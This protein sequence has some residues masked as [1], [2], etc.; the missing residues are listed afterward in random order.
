MTKLDIYTR[1]HTVN[2]SDSDQEE[3]VAENDPPRLPPS[4]VVLDTETT[5]DLGLD[6]EFGCYAVCDWLDGIYV[7]REY[8]ILFDKLKSEFEQV[9]REYADC[10]PS[11][12]VEPGQ[13]KLR[14]RTHTDFIKNVFWPVLRAGGAAVGLNLGFDLSRIAIGYSEKQ[15]GRSFDFF[16]R[17]YL[18]KKTGKRKLSSVVPAIT[19]TSIDSKKSFYGLHFSFAHKADG[20]PVLSKEEVAEFRKSRFVDVRT[21]AFSLTN[22]SYSL[23]TLLIALD[24]PADVMKLKYVPGP[25]TE[26]KIEYCFHDV[27][28]TLWALNKLVAEFLRH[29]IKLPIDR[30]YSPVSLA[31]SYLKKMNIIPPQEK[32]DIPPEFQAAA[33]EAFYAGRAETKIRKIEMPVVYLDFTSQYPSVFQLLRGQEIVIAESLAF[34]ECTAEA[35]ALLDGLKREDLF[36]RDVWPQL[37]FF[38]QLTPDGDILPVRAAYNGKTPNIAFNHFVYDQPIFYA[39]PELADAK[40]SGNGKSPKLLKAFRVVP[41]GIQPGLGPVMLRGEVPIDPLEGDLAP[42]IVESRARVKKSNRWLA[43]FLKVMANGGMFYGLFAQVSP[44]RKDQEVAVQVFTGNQTF[45]SLTRDIEKTGDWYCPLLA[46]LIVSAGHLLLAMAERSV[47]DAGSC[48]VLMDTDSLAAVSSEHSRFIPCPGGPHRLP[49]GREAVKALS[50][51]ETLETVVEPFDRLHP[52]D[53]NRV[54]DHFLK[55]DDINLG[56]DGRQRQLYAFSISSK[57]YCLYTYSGDGKRKI[58]KVSAHGLGYLMPPFDDPPEARKTEGREEHKWI[59]EAWEWILA[60]ELDG[61]EAARSY[62]MPWFAYPAMMQLT[63]TTPHAI[64]RLKH[65]PW[66]RPMNFMNAPLIAH[67]LLP[68]EV[69]ADHFSLVGPYNPNSAMWSD[70]TYFNRYDGKPYRIGVEPDAIPYLSYGSILQS[71]RLHPESKFLGPDG[72]TCNSDTRGVLQR[73]TVDGI[74]KYPLRKESNRRWA[75]GNDLSLIEDDEDDPTGGIFKRDGKQS[76]HHVKQPLPA[77]VQ[78]WLNTLS[79]KLIERELRIDRNSLRNG[80]NGK[81]VARIAQKK[82]LVLFRMAKRGI[83]VTEALKA[84]RSASAMLGKLQ[85]SKLRPRNKVVADPTLKNKIANC[86]LRELM[87]ETGLS[88]HTIEAI[89][90]GKAIRRKTLQRVVQFLDGR[91]G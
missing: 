16:T 72:A 68:P 78:E 38:G 8:G 31:K 59:Y 56:P 63:V 47:R 81:P 89:R 43:N 40:I 27:K 6:L 70:A 30:A 84:M 44:E 24:A 51:E 4:V 25:I 26:E 79:L 33:M 86:G 64:K 39:G 71:Y 91:R 35:Q 14:V 60:R 82:L 61:E 48:H 62:R 69:A 80:R 87:R 57:R 73:M 66:A 9:I 42:K 67:A 53:R 21:L 37:R 85:N 36:E 55:V 41:Q 76:Y 13:P 23:E 7:P 83:G 19:R 45:V 34:E 3:D 20:S 58:V 90:A 10:H 75:E 12:I 15:D 54:E 2:L 28:G 65:M 52:Y 29:P 32:F 77:E 74:T 88:Q 50:W 18:D 17:D 11:G 22:Q 49:D 5:E 1:V 46:S